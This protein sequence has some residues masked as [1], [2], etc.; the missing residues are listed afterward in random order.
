MLFGLL[1]AVGVASAT[2]SASSSS[3]YD[4][5]GGT[6][7]PGTYS[8][9]TITGVCYMPAGN[10]VVRHDLVVQ[11]GALLDAVTPGDPASKPLVPATVSV[12]GN[13]RVREGAVL[14]LGCS[15]AISCKTGVTYDHIA[16]NLTAT[17]ALGVIVHSIVVGGSLSILGG[18][19]GVVGGVATGVCDGSKTTPAPVPP[20]WLKDPSLA[21]GEG[22]GHPVP[23][24]SDVEDSSIGG[25]LTIADLR[26]CWV[27]SLRNVVHGNAVFVKNKMGDPDALEVGSNL[28]SRNMACLANDPRVQFGDSGA[29]PNMVKGSGF[30]ECGF[31]VILPN[32]PPEA[33]AGVGL[34]EHITV[35]TKTLKAFTGIHRRTSSKEILFGQ[36]E[37]NDTLAGEKNTVVLTGTALTGSVKEKVLVTIFPNGSQSFMALDL[38]TCS[39]HGHSGTVA[40]EAYGTQT[41]SGVVTGYFLIVSG[42]TG[43]S[44][45]GKL[46]GYGTFSS[47]GQPHL[48]LSTVTYLK[49]T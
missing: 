2:S 29:A 10:I 8:S 23:V 32:P 26:S 12:R 17:S 42:G 27:G 7:A 25:S 21:N 6:V 37:S 43:H 35:S 5:T 30:G 34:P 41:V 19:G 48:D 40:I 38:C 31:N 22:P 4:C 33:G 11:R 47:V 18:G 39:F 1:A 45:L 14:L 9:I 24:Y 20:L 44:G 13:V 16:G 46:A 3:A 28:I 15:P 36:T 49:I